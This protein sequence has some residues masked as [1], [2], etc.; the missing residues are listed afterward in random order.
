MMREKPC[1]IPEAE[2]PTRLSEPKIDA[3]RRSLI[4]TVDLCSV[5]C[6]QD[7]V[8]AKDAYR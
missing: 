1:Q 8:I 3:F 2:E 7:D 5:H 4:E 6:L